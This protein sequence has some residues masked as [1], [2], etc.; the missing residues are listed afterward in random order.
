MKALAYSVVV[1]SIG[2]AARAQPNP[3]IQTE[4]RVVLV[5]AI[6]IAKNGTYV[7]D[8]TAKDFRVWQDNREQAIKSFS[9]EASSSAAQPRSLVL[10]FD[11]AGM[12]IPDQIVVRQAASGFIDAETGPNRRM[13]VVTYNGT[14]RVAQTFTEN[15]GR[16]KEA[17]P[18]PESNSTQPENPSA[19]RQAA[20]PVNTARGELG[21]RY[22]LKALQSLCATLEPLPGRKIAV[23]FSASLPS[24]SMQRSEARDLVET[25]NRSDVAI[26]PA[27]VRPV[28]AQLD[29]DP[30][31]TAPPDRS[32]LPRGRSQLPPAQPHGDAADDLGVP[33]ESGAAGQQMM[34]NLANGTGGFVIRN[35]NDL[36]AELQRIAAEQEAYYAFTYTPPESKEGACHTIRVKVDRGGTTVR[37]RKSYCTKTQ[38]LVTATAAGKELEKRVAGAEAS[39]IPATMALSYFY[40][41]PDRAR[42]H[43]AMEIAPGAVKFE[44][45]KGKLH[46]ELNLVGIATTAEGEVR[47]RFSDVL[48]LNFENQAQADNLKAKTIHYEKQFQISPG[49]YTFTMAVRQAVASFGKLEMPLSVDPWNGTELAV[50]SLVLSRETRQAGD[51]GLSLMAED[52][53]P[54]IAE[55]IEVIPLGTAQ[56]AQSEPG[57]F[58][59]EVYAADA[60]SVRVRLRI[61]DRNSG[62]AKWNSGPMKL[63]VPNSG[64]KIA[65]IAAGS[66]LP[67]GLL[68]PGAYQL[69]V[70]VSDS[71]GQQVKRTADLEI[72]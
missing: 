59:L 60:S 57:F 10:F 68:S 54:L 17:L 49:K 43:M 26:Y 51:S 41:A 13:A 33:Q 15:A 23:L 12:E 39:T 6:V 8:L 53:T 1:S 61:V 55:G 7:R 35:S 52:R 63:P 36:L 30:S 25:C 21:A 9:L 32:R 28:S 64:A 29:S 5:D 3:V 72:K 16:L 71:S 65:K 11:E 47:A 24:T 66:P 19:R 22:M 46:A 40:V 70:T 14:L 42:V 56:L 20:T 48:S 18:S 45:Q 2:I 44:N 58:Y 34:F 4:A 37:A 67:L 38:D 62:E 27:D 31:P 69:E 50:S